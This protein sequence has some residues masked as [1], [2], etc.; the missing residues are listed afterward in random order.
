MITELMAVERVGVQ[1]ERQLETRET[2]FDS[3]YISLEKA[4]RQLSFFFK[5]EEKS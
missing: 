2:A 5:K 1:S 4:E 3:N